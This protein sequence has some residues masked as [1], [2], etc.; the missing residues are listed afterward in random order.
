MLI[1]V[2]ISRFAAGQRQAGRLAR[3]SRRRRSS[4]PDRREPYLHRPGPAGPWPHR[5]NRQVRALRPVMTGAGSSTPAP[6]RGS[7]R[8]GQRESRPEGALP[9]SG[10]RGSPPPPGPG[11]PRPCPHTRA[12]HPGVRRRAPPDTSSTQSSAAC[13]TGARRPA[14]VPWSWHEHRGSERSVNVQ[15]CEEMP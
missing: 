10:G 8:H 6:L 15:L 12:R 7:S 4:R 9:R 13:S 2:I 11:R 5:D 14:C 1:W 3:G